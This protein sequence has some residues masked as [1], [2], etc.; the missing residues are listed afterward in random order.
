MPRCTF[1]VMS[2]RPRKDEDAPF[3]SVEH[4]I[5]GLDRCAGRESR[6]FVRARTDDR[7]GVEVASTGPRNLLDQTHVFRNVNQLDI[8]DAG[9]I[10]FVDRPIVEHP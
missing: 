3:F 10:R 1:G 6:N 9:E 5:H 7:V 4:Q 8:V 2:R